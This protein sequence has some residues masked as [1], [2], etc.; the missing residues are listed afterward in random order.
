MPASVIDCHLSNIIAC[1]KSN[2]KCSK[3]AKTA[4]VTPIF[5]K[6]DITKLKTTGL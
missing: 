1:D 4:T 3:H 5:K 2:N 6:D